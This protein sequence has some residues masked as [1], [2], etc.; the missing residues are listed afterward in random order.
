MRH[1]IT[2]SPNLLCFPKTI[3]ELGP[4]DSLAVGLSALISGVE[5]VYALDIIPCVSDTKETIQTFDN[6]VNLFFEKALI[7]TDKEFIDI[8]PTLESSSFPAGVLPDDLLNSSM[9]PMRLELIRSSLVKRGGSS[10]HDDQSI[11]HLMSNSATTII[12]PES[13]D[14]V[15]SQAVMEHVGNVETVYRDLYG[16]LKP[17]GIMSH[18]I[19]FQSHGVT[20]T[21]NGHWAYSDFHWRIITGK[22]TCFL[23]RWT[24]SMHLEAIQ[25]AGFILLRL[26]TYKDHYVFDRPGEIYK[27]D[28]ISLSDFEI[29]GAVIQA[30]KP[31]K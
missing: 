9:D 31:E 16:W 19:D 30:A 27:S 15:V 5:K 4:G 8:K 23:N 29:T 7:P 13:L 14:M 26:L 24:F 12:R 1:L 20:E 10:S 6:L 28:K 11:V 22:R 25:R 17:G 3:L 21:W 18:M 2:A